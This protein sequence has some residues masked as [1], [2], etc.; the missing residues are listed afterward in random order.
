MT[1]DAVLVVPDTDVL[2]QPTAPCEIIRSHW[3]VLIDAPVQGFEGPHMLGCQ[4]EASARARLRCW[5]EDRPDANPQLIRR[6]VVE[7]FGEWEA[8]R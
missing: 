5:Q 3:A 1:N 7:T 2:G 4:D 6:K 8:T